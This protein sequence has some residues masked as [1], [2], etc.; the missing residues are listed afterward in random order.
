MYRYIMAFFVFSFMGWVWESIY[1]TAKQKKWA[2]RGFL[3]GPICP[4]YGFGGS[5]GLFVFDHI[6]VGNVTDL[7]WW[8]IFIAGF[9]VSMILEYPTSWALEKLFHARWWDYT[10]VPLNINGRTSVPTSIAFGVAAIFVMKVFLPFADTKMFILPDNI[11]S[12]LSLILIA[13][14]SSD[15]TLTVTALTDFEK[16]VTALDEQFQ[17]HMTLAVDHLYE[18]KHSLRQNAL[19]RIVKI[20]L[21][22]RKAAIAKQLIDRKVEELE[23]VLKKD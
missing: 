3:Y 4:I 17:E 20:Q 6:Q 1:C 18:P 13:I 15:F 10:N 21:P 9:L 19:D 5:F 8:Q 12:I 22:H 7:T 23:D 16:K 2:N 11:A 14:I